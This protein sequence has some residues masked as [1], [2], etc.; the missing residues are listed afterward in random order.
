LRDIKTL[1]QLLAYLRDELDWPIGSDDVENVTFDYSREELGL[2]AKHV[3]GIKEIK[4]LRPL[5]ANQP[6][7][8]F[9]VNFEKKRLPVTIMRL[10]LAALR[11]HKRTPAERA[12][13][14]AWEP[15]DLLFISAYG[16]EGDRALTFAH[17]V[18]TNPGSRIAELR[19]LG[20]DD[21]DTPL[22]YDYI[23]VTLN[24]KLRWRN[25]FAR[26]PDKWRTEWSDAF[27]LRHRQVITTSRELALALAA[28]ANRI[29]ARVRSLLKM[30]D[31]FGQMRRLLGAFQRAL[32]HD[33]DDDDFA[34]MIAQTVT[35]GLFS[36]SVRRTVP[37]EGT[38][39]T[40]EDIPHYIFTSPFLKEMMTTFL[41]L[42]TRKGKIDFDRLGIADVTDILQSPDTKMELVLRDFGNRTRGEDP[43]IHFYEDFL[44]EYDPE[45]RV[46]RGVFYTPQ[47]VVSYIVR[48]VHELLQTEFKLEHGLADTTTWGEMVRRNPGLK[49]PNISGDPDEYQP[50]SESEPFVQIL[51]PAVGT[52]TFLVEV[53][54]VIYRHLKTKWELGGLKDMPKL[55]ATSFTRQP[56]DFSEYWNQYVAFSLLPRLHGFEL[57]MA[58]YAIAHMRIGLKLLET[59]FRLTATSA[60]TFT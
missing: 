36:V 32:I 21:D 13:R 18:P 28:A 19:V 52:A 4:Q 23:A 17:F 48:S 3:A 57:M 8:I 39:V 5:N 16:E 45:K 11:I 34:D 49:L 37:G 7:G 22:K 10:I 31:G 55:P 14:Q 1:P 59:G 12:G 6:W 15:Q 40:R 42:K 47:P 26:D 30:E 60:R 2:D 43:V 46:K 27:I 53:T 51:D 20:W 54:D 56:M 9:F 29:R 50:L 38:A 58:P 24:E 25:E 44:R 33:L 41:G 35:Y